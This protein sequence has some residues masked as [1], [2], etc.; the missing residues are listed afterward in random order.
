VL[1]GIGGTEIVDAALLMYGS[2]SMD[3]PGKIRLVRKS[4]GMWMNTGVVSSLL[5]RL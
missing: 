1:M 5:R 3:V 2:A 4:T